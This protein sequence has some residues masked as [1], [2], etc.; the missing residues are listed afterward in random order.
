MGQAHSVAQSRIQLPL[1]CNRM[2]SHSLSNFFNTFSSLLSKNHHLVFP[3]PSCLLVLRFTAILLPTEVSFFRVALTA[4]G[5]VHGNVPHTLLTPFTDDF[6]KLED[7]E[8]L[9]EPGGELALFSHSSSP[10]QYSTPVV[11]STVPFRHSTPPNSHSRSRWSGMMEWNGGMD[12]WSGAL[13]WTTGVP[14]P[15]I[16]CLGM[17]IILS[18][19]KDC[20]KYM[21]QDH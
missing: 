4:P 9:E 1:R 15:Q 13:D 6:G 21:S 17:C 8:L 12:Y 20:T 18:Y 2:V 5:V 16:G 14:R 19:F 7:W 3:E 11:H 10:V